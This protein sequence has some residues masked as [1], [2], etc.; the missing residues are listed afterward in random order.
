MTLS[1]I[2][3]DTPGEPLDERFNA[4]RCVRKRPPSLGSHCE[5]ESPLM[6]PRPG[7]RSP[8]EPFVVDQTAQIQR[9]PRGVNV[10]YTPLSRRELPPS[11]HPLG[12]HMRRLTLLALACVIGVLT[13]A[14]SRPAGTLE[15]ATEA[16]GATEL[17]SIEYSGTGR[18]FQFG[19]APSP[20]LPW[21][22]F[23][24][25]SF[26]ATVDYQTPG[27]RVQMARSQTVEPGR[28]RP[29]PVEQRPVQYR[30]RHVR[31]EH[32]RR[33]RARRPTRAPAPQPQ[34]AAVEERAMEIW[35]TPHGFLKAAA[36]N[37]ATSQPAEGG[38]E[39]SFTVDGKH[40][41]VGPDQRAEPGGARPDLDRQP[42]PRRHARRVRLLRLPRFR[43][44]HVPGPHRADA[45][46][47]SGAGHHRL[48]GHRQSRASTSQVP[49][50][51]AQLCASGRDASPSR[52]SPTAST[53]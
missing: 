40:Q 33:P 10:A 23:D 6:D 43:R 31:L 29:A 37:N 17:R 26:T 46:W 41:Y 11:L 39:V 48:V 19:Q 38:S 27:A 50:A 13:S 47:A 8:R 7:Q 12:G 49:E 9:A 44:R 36:A 21:P 1:D 4:T 28:T 3:R 53:T 16:L 2:R 32:G 5:S 45:G 20:T 51:V 52:S 15:A 25:S 14:C 18:W 22:Q 35:T 42:G 24:V 30:Q 34:P